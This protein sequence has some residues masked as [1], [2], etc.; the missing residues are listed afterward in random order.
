MEDILSRLTGLAVFLVIGVMAVLPVVVAG[1]RKT[2][3]IGAVA[4]ITLLLG[5][6][7]IGWIVALAMAAGGAPKPPLLSTFPP[8]GPPGT[9]A[10]WY[11]DPNNPA[12]WLRWWDGY[13]WT[14]NTQQ[15][16][17]VSPAM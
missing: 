6:T 11:A 3:N 2:A 1:K 4:V 9:P 13:Q 17:D 8:P 5:W 7:V 16:G 15:A 14:M 10:G 12:A